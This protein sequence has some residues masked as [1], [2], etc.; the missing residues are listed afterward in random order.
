MAEIITTADK[1]IKLWVFH[2]Y[3]KSINYVFPNGDRAEFVNGKYHTSDE[4]KANH[5]T[6]EIKRGVRAF[7]VKPGEETIMSDDLD[8]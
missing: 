3:T 7:Y 6:N 8:R 4:D 1:P 2:S 5:L